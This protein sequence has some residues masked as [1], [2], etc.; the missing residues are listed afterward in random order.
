MNSCV[1]CQEGPGTPTPTPTPRHP[2]APTPRRP[3][4]P[5]PTPTGCGLSYEGDE[6]ERERVHEQ[7]CELPGGT[8]DPDPDAPTPRCPD[9]PTPRRPDA[10]TPRRPD[11]PTPRRPDAPTLTPTSC[12]LSYA[13]DE[14]ERERESP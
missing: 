7:L 6:R 1:S 12:G 13:G 5:T 3:D 9:A 2:D 4:A 8:W 11:A 10:P 14:R